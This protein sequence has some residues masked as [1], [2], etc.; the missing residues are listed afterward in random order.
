M[1]ARNWLCK[2]VRRILLG[3]VSAAIPTLK[4][5][6]ERE[7]NKFTLESVPKEIREIADIELD[8]GLAKYWVHGRGSTMINFSKD[9]LEVVR[10]GACYEVIKDV[11]KK[12][13]NVEL[14][15]DPGREALPF[16]NVNHLPP[17][18]SLRKLIE[19]T[20]GVE[21]MN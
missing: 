7:G 17:S 15:E 4:I 9:E 21:I 8:Y 3:R 18:E 12:F 5:K 1:R 10:I 6:T 16:G 2:G 20:K 13:W 19:K 11:L 14:P